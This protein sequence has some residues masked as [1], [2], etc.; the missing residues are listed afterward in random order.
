MLLPQSDTGEESPQRRLK[1]NFAVILLLTIKA[2]DVPSFL[3]GIF[4]I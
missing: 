4:F 2:M 1:K 3:N